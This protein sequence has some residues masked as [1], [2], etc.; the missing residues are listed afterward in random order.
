MGAPEKTGAPHETGWCAGAMI[1]KPRVGTSAL[2][3][4]AGIELPLDVIDSVEMED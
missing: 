3:G 4:V 2:P 1:G